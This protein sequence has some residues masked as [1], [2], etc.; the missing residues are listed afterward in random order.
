MENSYPII[1]L[2][3]HKRDVSIQKSVH[4]KRLINSSMI[5]TG[6]YLV[7]LVLVVIIRFMLVDQF[8]KL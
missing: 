8:K 4:K 2:V 1:N 7:L 3:G 5:G 6:V